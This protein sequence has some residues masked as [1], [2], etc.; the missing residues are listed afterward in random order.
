MRRIKR[1]R[2]EELENDFSKKVIDENDN[3]YEMNKTEYMPNKNDK[4]VSKYFLI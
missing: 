3:D 4:N 2:A 1:I